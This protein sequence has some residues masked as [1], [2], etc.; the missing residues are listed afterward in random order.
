MSGVA[1]IAVSRS[2]T[3]GVVPAYVITIGCS[4]STPVPWI[5]LAATK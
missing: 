3:H 4:S 5:N 1:A 2:G